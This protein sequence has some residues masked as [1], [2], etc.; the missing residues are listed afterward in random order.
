MKVKKAF[1]RLGY[2]A[3]KQGAVNP[4]INYL[5]SL[6]LVHEKIKLQFSILNLNDKGLIKLT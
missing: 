5:S 4:T 2:V 1:I 3:D 6:R